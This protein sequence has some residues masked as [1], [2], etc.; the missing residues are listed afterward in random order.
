[1]EIL[2][3]NHDNVLGTFFLFILLFTW[4][5]IQK[6]GGGE[7]SFVVRSS[8]HVINVKDHRFIGHDDPLLHI[9]KLPVPPHQGGQA[10]PQLPADRRTTRTLL[11][12]HSGPDPKNTGPI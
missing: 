8:Y 11:W 7:F 3:L 1:M 6:G 12:V 9:E 2:Q 10:S 4:Y 5:P